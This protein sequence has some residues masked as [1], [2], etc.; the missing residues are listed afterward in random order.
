MLGLL[1]GWSL[2]CLQGQSKLP[3]PT[4]ADLDKLVVQYRD[5]HLPFPP[6]GSPLIETGSA[7]EFRIQ[8]KLRELK[9]WGYLIRKAAKPDDDSSVMVG[10]ITEESRL[11]TPIKPVALTPQSVK[12]L[13]VIQTTG[14]SFDED[15]GLA[16]AVIERSRG[17]GDFALEVIKSIS[18]WEYGFWGGIAA[19]YKSNLSVKMQY[20]ALQ[21]W[22]NELLRKNSDRD[23]IAQ[24][25]N[26][27]GAKYPEMTKDKSWEP[28]RALNLE[29]KNRYTGTD[30]I[31]KAIDAL[32]DSVNNGSSLDIDHTY[33]STSLGPVLK[34]VDFGYKAIPNLVRHFDD[35][36]LSRSQPSGLVNMS[37]Y[38]VPVGEI[39]MNLADHY[40][41]RVEGTK[42]AFSASIDVRK[43]AFL[44][45]WKIASC[46]SD[47]ENCR[48]EMMKGEDMPE[49][50][51]SLAEKKYP[52][53]VLDAYNHI[54]NSKKKTQTW[55][56]LAS[57]ERS[58]LPR[59]KVINA[60]LRGA[61]HENFDRA[62]SGIWTLWDLDKK[63][64]D[65][66]L[67]KVL[68]RLPRHTSG[69]HWLSTEPS[70][71]QQA[72]HSSSPKVWAALTQA[73]LRADVDLRL[74]LLRSTSEVKSKSQNRLEKL[75][76]LRT[77][78]G[79]DEVA[80]APPKTEKDPFPE[81]GHPFLKS[82]RV[83]DL[84][85]VFAAEEF[86]IKEIPS[87]GDSRSKWDSFRTNIATKIDL[88]LKK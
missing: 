14:S 16:L 12:D 36:R 85:T 51:C 54:L 80:V 35:K 49:A 83:Q 15:G 33:P 10:T 32:C 73:S 39:C 6:T 86:N 46:R 87:D 40:Y 28:V 30:P 84:A 7:G 17:H 18:S 52:S 50:A 48:V 45:W 23:L 81:S 77:F 24:E 63:A 26:R 4:F 37:S 27:L 65:Q 57:M 58:S 19:P 74:E 68:N 21:H 20:L 11:E 3:A 70:F 44:K 43:A 79:D 62:H 72:A 69:D 1:C 61:R 64:F 5:L 34:L 25:L 66:E 53:L 82:K 38:I 56:L 31:E 60:A 59:K 55:L 76:Y 13:C 75:R 2:V 88:E 78:F 42:W 67:V 47:F 71:G 29:I 41:T 8:D 9:S 22:M